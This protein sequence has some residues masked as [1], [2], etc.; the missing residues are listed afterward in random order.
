VFP[1]YNL[2][3]LVI[4]DENDK[5]KYSIYGKDKGIYSTWG[6]T[7]YLPPHNAVHSFDPESPGSDIV[8]VYDNQIMQLAPV[9]SGSVS[10]MNL[11][12]EPGAFYSDRYSRWIYAGNTGTQSFNPYKPTDNTANI[13]LVYIDYDGNP[14]IAAGSSFP[15]SIS[16]TSV[17]F[18]Y[19][20]EMPND[21][22][23]PIC[24]VRLV[25]GTSALS[26]NDIYPLRQFPAGYNL[27]P[28]TGQAIFTIEGDVSV[29]S[30]SIRIYNHLGRTAH[31]IGVYL[32]ADTAPVGADM[33]IDIHKSGTTIFTN[34]ANR[35]R[36]VD[37]NNTGNT[38]TIDVPNWA[39]GSYLTMDRDQ[40]GSG[41]AGSDLTVTV[42]YK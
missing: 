38:T 40:V 42:V 1:V 36:I 9:P 2:Q 28:Q 29:G 7:A 16:G 8:W 4:R 19:L 13:N 30:G 6:M 18:Q 41:T 26:W 14:K 3:V 10:G 22:E 23:I 5:N 31:I 17:V 11:I 24:A 39:N 34:Q 15:A 32:A 37:G 33:I 21:I 27:S 12:I 20:P 35:P 25:S